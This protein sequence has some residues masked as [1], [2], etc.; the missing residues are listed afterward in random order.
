MKL[1]QGR[2]ADTTNRLDKEIR[3]YDLLERLGV[4]YDRVDHAPA[5][6][7][8]YIK[9]KLYR[10][11]CCR[12]KPAAAFSFQLLKYQFPVESGSACSNMQIRTRAR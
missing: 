12:I 5:M 11:N 2:P 3:T 8:T 6:G 4:A 7:H 10:K 9:V 1:Q